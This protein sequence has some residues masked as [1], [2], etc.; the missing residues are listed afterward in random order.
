M[1][2]GVDV[3]VIHH[4]HKRHAGWEQGVVNVGRK[5]AP[6]VQ[7]KGYGDEDLSTINRGPHV[8]L[9]HASTW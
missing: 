4:R 2:D 6:V 9:G 8:Y 1:V 7:R 5:K 3:V